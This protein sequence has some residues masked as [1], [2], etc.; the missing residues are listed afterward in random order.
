MTQQLPFCCL[1][2]FTQTNYK[3]FTQ[4]TYTTVK[5]KDPIPT[6]DMME[7]LMA[8]FPANQNYFDNHSTYDYI[9]NWTPLGPI[10]PMNQKERAGDQNITVITFGKGTENLPV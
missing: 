5:K 9:T 3:T 7:F 6:T 10:T 8:S 1:Y 4:D 2:K